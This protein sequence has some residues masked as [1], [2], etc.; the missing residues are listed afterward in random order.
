MFDRV[1]NKARPSYGP[2]RPYFKQKQKNNLTTFWPIEFFLIYYFLLFEKINKNLYK[3]PK[4]RSII[5][6]IINYKIAGFSSVLVMQN[7][8]FKKIPTLRIN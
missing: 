6:I 7:I 2:D 4:R 8:I 5:V 1:L 3:Q